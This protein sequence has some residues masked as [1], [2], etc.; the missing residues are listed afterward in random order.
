MGLIQDLHERKLT[1]CR[2]CDA[3]R[4]GLYK[5]LD[6]WKPDNRIQAASTLDSFDASNLGAYVESALKARGGVGVSFATGDL[7][8]TEFRHDTTPRF[9]ITTRLHGDMTSQLPSG[10][11]ASFYDASD[12]LIVTCTTQDLNTFFATGFTSTSDNLCD[13]TFEGIEVPLGYTLTRWFENT[14]SPADLGTAGDVERL[15]IRLTS[16]QSVIGNYTGLQTLF[17]NRDGTASS[18]FDTYINADAPCWSDVTTS[19]TASIDAIFRWDKADLGGGDWRIHA[20]VASDVTPGP[21]GNW[22]FYYNGTTD[23][24]TKFMTIGFV[25]GGFTLCSG[26]TFPSSG[27][28]GSTALVQIDLPSGVE[29]NTVNR[30]QNANSV[31]WNVVMSPNRTL[32][33]TAP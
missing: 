20:K 24:V 30:I 6:L 12:T 21:T 14:G 26:G 13:S 15:E 3:I 23:F 25:A 5:G 10:T 4:N 8:V 16:D 1:G 9:R 28:I 27:N 17:C 2:G 31:T 33:V 32:L 18:G 22:R 7:A 29:P 11:E 19:T